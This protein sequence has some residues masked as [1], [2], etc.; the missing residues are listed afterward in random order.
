MLIYQ[1]KMSYSIKKPKFLSTKKFTREDWRKATVTAF[2]GAIVTSYASNI[3][4]AQ[5]IGVGLFL[6][7]VTSAVYW[8]KKR[9]NSDE[10]A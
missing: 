1:N 9:K 8:F 3:V 6:L 5:V 10:L 7:G 4:F 2:L